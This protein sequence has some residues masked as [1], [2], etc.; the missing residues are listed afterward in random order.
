MSDGQKSERMKIELGLAIFEAAL[1]VIN[2]N[3]DA[4][5]CM[6]TR[7]HIQQQHSDSPLANGKWYFSAARAHSSSLRGETL[8]Q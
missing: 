5:A 7:V 8:A 3:S 1:C 6:L 2:K 4:R